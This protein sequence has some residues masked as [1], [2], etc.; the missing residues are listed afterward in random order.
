MLGK[1]ERYDVLYTVLG[2]VDREVVG[3]QTVVKHARWLKSQNLTD[4]Y[5]YFESAQT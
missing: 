1:I 3:Y 2:S 4:R 5:A